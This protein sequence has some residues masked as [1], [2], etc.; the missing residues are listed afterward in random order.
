ME[1]ESHR[2]HVLRREAGLECEGAVCSRMS[3]IQKRVLTN[4]NSG[5]PC[6]LSQRLENPMGLSLQLMMT[7]PGAY[8]LD[9]HLTTPL[10]STTAPSIQ[11]AP[12]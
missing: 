11:S 8:R 6:A 12:T 5:N 10:S 9:G 3:T 4:P 1:L 2:L 7:F